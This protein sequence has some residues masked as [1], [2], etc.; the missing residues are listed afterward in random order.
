MNGLIRQVFT[1][2]KTSGAGLTAALVALLVYYDVLSV[3]GGVMWTSFV[4]AVGLV[5]SRDGDA[6]KLDK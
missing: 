5:L 4:L 1:N 3:E 6:P 2:W